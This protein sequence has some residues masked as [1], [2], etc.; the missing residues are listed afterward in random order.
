MNMPPQTAC[1]I[2][3][4]MVFLEKLAGH[5]ARTGGEMVTNSW[6]ENLKERNHLEDLGV[7]VEAEVPMLKYVP[8]HEDVGGVE[9]QLHAFFILAL[10]GGASC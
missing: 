7:E 10:D 8:S 9:A 2:F 4:S 1:N 6:S 5:V 3:V